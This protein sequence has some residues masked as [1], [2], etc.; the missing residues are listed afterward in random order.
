M[1]S[2]TG[3]LVAIATCV[4]LSA[5]TSPAQRVQNKENML[6]AS[7]F[8]FT[9]ANTPQRQASLASLPPHKFVPQV[10]DNKMIYIYA[11]PTIC[12]CLY[13][14]NQ[15]AYGR[16]RENVFQKNLANEQQ[17]T[18]EMNQNM[19]WGPWGGPGWYYY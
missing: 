14:G 3:S 9:P 2:L 6:V 16:Y 18:A 10:R 4:V 15:A 13:V 7:G 11:D 1:A 12:G 8:R 5:C 17:M 19:D